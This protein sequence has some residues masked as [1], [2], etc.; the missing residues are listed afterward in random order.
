MVG[1]LLGPCPPPLPRSEST[2]STLTEGC[3]PR[4]ELSV[5]KAQAG[6]QRRAL[7]NTAAGCQTGPQDRAA[8]AQSRWL[9]QAEA[10]QAGAKRRFTE[11][12]VK[13]ILMCG[14]TIFLTS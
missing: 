14:T 4:L 11:I 1:M 7:A 2:S 9:L 10:G 6:G 3:G 5:R 13:R 8:S 12:Y